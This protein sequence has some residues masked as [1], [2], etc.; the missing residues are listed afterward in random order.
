MKVDCEG[1]THPIEMFFIILNIDLTIFW[2]NE[3]QG[4][5]RGVIDSVI[6]LMKWIHFQCLIIHILRSFFKGKY[7]GRFHPL[8]QPPGGIDKHF[9]KKK[10]GKG[11]QISSSW[12]K[13]SPQ[14]RIFDQF[15]A[16]LWKKCKNFSF[17][18]YPISLNLCLLCCT[19]PLKHCGKQGRNSLPWFLGVGKK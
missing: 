9:E 5:T 13:I 10:Q 3:V 4:I 19:W 2:S 17:I 15:L 8:P 12:P 11:E 1:L 7:S 14:I 16:I 18:F 6:K